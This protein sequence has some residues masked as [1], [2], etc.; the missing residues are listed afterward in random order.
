M[1]VPMNFSAVSSYLDRL[2]QGTPDTKGMGISSGENRFDQL[3]NDPAL[4]T[5]GLDGVE[6]M[7]GLGTEKDGSDN[8]SIMEQTLTGSMQLGNMQALATLTKVLGN[9]QNPVA[10]M[11]R[12]LMGNTEEIPSAASAIRM[13]VSSPMQGIGGVSTLPTLSTSQPLFQTTGVNEM[14]SPAQ[15]TAQSATIPSVVSPDTSNVHVTKP[16]QVISTPVSAQPSYKPLS[17][18]TTQEGY[19]PGALSAM[20]ES[21]SRGGSSAIGYD[22]NG[23]TSYG[24][25]QLSSRAGTL[26]RFLG[27]LDHKAPGFAKTLRA[28]GPANTGSRSG[29]MPTAWKKIAGTYPERFEKLQNQFIQSTNFAPALN[30]VTKAMG[31]GNLS[32]A[33]QEVLFST[34]IQHGP[35]GA[36]RIFA[37]AF[38]KLGS[39]P[40]IALTD[41]N[42]GDFIRNIYEVRAMQFGKSSA[43][44]R[45]AVHTRLASE[46]RIALD[47][48]SSSGLA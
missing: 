26:D 6:K 23:G 44:V 25:F 36:T 8:M 2:K 43:P 45:R 18:P 42:A 29:N 48:L 41:E 15:K 38:N 4:Q 16:Q 47:M 28:A 20:F 35:T 5:N 30:A 22:R 32:P 46:M 40:S 10:S 1:I 11:F 34:A 37:K 19:E 14:T 3:L 39:S 21:G 12:N 33:L 27:F 7:L 9:E 17:T 13:P 31:L 24:K